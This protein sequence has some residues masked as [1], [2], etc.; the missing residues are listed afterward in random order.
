MCLA[1][2]TQM[3]LQKCEQGSQGAGLYPCSFP[4]KVKDDPLLKV[5]KNPTTDCSLMQFH[6][7]KK[8]HIECEFAKK[9]KYPQ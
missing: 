2:G 9:E 1:V 6:T 7:P 3:T 4:E 8:E 5:I